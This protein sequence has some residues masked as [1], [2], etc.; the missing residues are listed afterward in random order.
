MAPRRAVPRTNRAGW[1]TRRLAG[2]VALERREFS[3]ETG[4]R[5]AERQD[6]RALFT[7]PDEDLNTDKTLPPVYPA[8]KPWFDNGQMVDAPG[9]I[10]ENIR[11]DQYAVLRFATLMLQ[12]CL[13]LGLKVNLTPF[14]RGGGESLNWNISVEGATSD[15]VAAREASWP[16][17]YADGTHA[18]ADVAGGLPSWQSGILVPSSAGWDPSYWDSASYPDIPAAGDASATIHEQY[19]VNVWPTGDTVAADG[20]YPADA[21]PYREECARRKSLAI[22]AFATGIGEWLA[23]FHLALGQA[24]RGFG[25]GDPPLGIYDV[26]NAIELGNE[27]NGFWPTGSPV[28]GSPGQYTASAIAQGAMEAGRYCAL[29]AGPIRHLLPK[30]RFRLT[31]LASWGVRTLETGTVVDEFSTNVAWLA[32]VVSAMN[33]EVGWWRTIQT[34]GRAPVPG[35][36]EWRASGAA[37]GFHWPPP[38]AFGRRHAPAL[39]RR[40]GPRARIPLVPRQG[41]RARRTSQHD[42]LRGRRA[43]SG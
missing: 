25:D 27:F 6:R 1:R 21:T 15:V 34:A 14:N 26:V 29:V 8:G 13:L 31:E 10:L 30:M 9:V 2:F 32:L 4:A 37:A 38:L 36:P 39:G 18:W 3:A 43:A 5:Y 19:A 41:S 22:A 11:A 40:S 23:H 20:S 42:R 24:S 12:R 7:N 28:T 35:V 17:A 16:I 33:A